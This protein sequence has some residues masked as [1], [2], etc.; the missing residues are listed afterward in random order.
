[1]EEIPRAGS[2][3]MGNAHSWGKVSNG[4]FQQ[5]ELGP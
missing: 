4:R 1:M 3:E 5:D 2:P